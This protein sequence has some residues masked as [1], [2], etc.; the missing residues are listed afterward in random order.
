MII[1]LDTNVIL[2]YLLKRERFDQAKAIIDLTNTDDQVE[3]VTASAGTDICYICQKQVG[4]FAAQ[5]M[6]DDLMKM[7]V[8]L[9]VK[10]ENLKDAIVLHW[11]DYEDALQY[12]VAVSKKPAPYWRQLSTHKEPL[13]PGRDIGMIPLSL[14]FS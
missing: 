5:Q 2:D 3:C 8:F 11:N 12:C 14:G 13:L 1:L 7:L 4:S 10:E 6:L 9:E